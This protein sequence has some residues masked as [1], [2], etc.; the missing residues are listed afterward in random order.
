MKELFDWKK[1]EYEK[2]DEKCDC[3]GRTYP[4]IATSY[5]LCI[6]C[7][8]QYPMGKA[9]RNLYLGEEE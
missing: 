8:K 3:D 7:G 1:Y 5:M 9:E 6:D 4:L 2:M